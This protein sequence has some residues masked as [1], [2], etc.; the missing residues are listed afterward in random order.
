MAGRLELIGSAV[1]GEASALHLVISGDPGLFAIVRLSVMISLSAVFFAALIGVPA[2]AFLALNRFHG[3]EGVIVLLNA[4]MGLPPVVVGLAVFLV[5][6][7]SGPLGSWGL[8]FTP[9]AMV[10]AQTVLVC[11]W[12]IVMNSPP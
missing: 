4:L 11:G 6:S 5:L 12:S 1:T 8:L 7:R 3:H 2:G 10:I 9:L